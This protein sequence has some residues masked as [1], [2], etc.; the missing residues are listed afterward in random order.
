MAIP[1]PDIGFAVQQAVQDEV[2]SVKNDEGSV[3][4]FAQP[5]LEFARE[6]RAW[7]VGGADFIIRKGVEQFLKKGADD[8]LAGVTRKNMAKEAGSAMKPRS[9]DELNAAARAGDASA[10]KDLGMQVS[11]HNA[12]SSSAGQLLVELAKAHPAAMTAIENVLA[13]SL[14]TGPAQAGVSARAFRKWF[15]DT[16]MRIH[17]AK[18]NDFLRA[19]RR[20]PDPEVRKIADELATGP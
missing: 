14:A 1:Q 5:A 6:G 20:S 8:A 15:M 11:E 7:P 18:Y 19:A 3:R 13:E 10:F 16:A 4:A 12:Q 2:A 9:I 17:P